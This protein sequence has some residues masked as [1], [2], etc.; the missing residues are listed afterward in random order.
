[1]ITDPLNPAYNATVRVW[2]NRDGSIDRIYHRTNTVMARPAGPLYLLMCT[3]EGDSVDVTALD[4]QSFIEDDNNLW[5]VV[6]NRNGGTSLGAMAELGTAMSLSE[7]LR[8]ARAPHV[9]TKKAKP[10]VGVF[11]S[12]GRGSPVIAAWNL[13][14]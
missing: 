8:A 1:M 6:D 4:N 12:D 14:V 9:K 2:F 13:P 11:A 7:K 5:I 3:G 10:T